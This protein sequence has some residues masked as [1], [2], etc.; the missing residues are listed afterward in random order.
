MAVVLSGI[1]STRLEGSCVDPYRTILRVTGAA[2]CHL[3]L[4]IT[5]P[6]RIVKSFNERDGSGHLHTR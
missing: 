3:S 6:G 2:N 5:Y 1:E 4:A